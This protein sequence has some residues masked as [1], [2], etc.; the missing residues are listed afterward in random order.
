MKTVYSKLANLIA[1]LVVGMLLFAPMRFGSE[2]TLYAHP[3]SIRMN[4]G[5]S[6]PLTYRLDADNPAQAIRY[7]SANEAVAVVDA[8]GTVTAV[9]PGRT[10]VMLDSDSGARAKVQVV[11][12][13]E[14]YLTLEIF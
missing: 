13:A 10:Q 11:C 2:D 3:R 8:G 7:S 5:D 1:V 4:P 12:V 9:G 6:Y 14:F